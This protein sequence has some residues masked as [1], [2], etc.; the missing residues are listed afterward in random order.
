MY[1]HEPNKETG[2]PRMKVIYDGYLW[3]AK[4]HSDWHEETRI[5]AATVRKCLDRLKERQLI[6]Y[7]LS[8]FNGNSTPFIRVNWTMFEAKMKALNTA[9]DPDT[10]EHDPDMREQ[11]GLL[12]Q[13]TPLLPE[14]NPNTETTT[15]TTTEISTFT[16]PENS[17]VQSDT[18]TGGSTKSANGAVSSESPVPAL[19]AVYKLP[20]APGN[21]S[22]KQW[23]L[24]KPCYQL[25]EAI[26]AY[27]ADGDFG[28]YRKVVKH[29]DKAGSSV[30]DF[31]DYVEY[32]RRVE[33]K[34]N[35]L[36]TVTSLMGQGRVSRYLAHK[37]GWVSQHGQT[38]TLDVE[39]KNPAFLPQIEYGAKS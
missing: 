22:D 4:N 18:M 29:L 33:S 17:A 38:E 8:G 3:I 36:I 32:I 31:T 9:K 15:E 6:F 10:R 20:L 2:K 30:S 35:W 37:R 26:G 16:A 39:W 34:G 13:D 19:E 1:W 11:G 25:G 14:V 21:R 12:P 24:D 23:A 5:K 7:I 27:P 28:V